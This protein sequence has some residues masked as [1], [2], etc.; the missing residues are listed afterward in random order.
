MYLT[1]P[2]AFYEAYVV[3]HAGLLFRK[4]VIIVY[5]IYY[6]LMNV[7][8]RVPVDQVRARCSRCNLDSFHLPLEVLKEFQQAVNWFILSVGIP[9]K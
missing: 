5:S 4:Y 9:L 1:L 7:K 6:E 3:G 8:P 2:N